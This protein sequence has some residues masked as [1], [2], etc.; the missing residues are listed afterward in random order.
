MHEENRDQCIL[1]SGESGSGKTEASKKILQYLAAAT[2]HSKKVD[3]VKDKLLQS[4]PVLE[5]EPVGGHILNYLLEK[6]R[7]VTQTNGERNFHVFYQLL[8]SAD[9][10]MLK[11]FHLRADADYYCYL[12]QGDCPVVEGIN[13]CSQF[14]TV[15]TA[16]ETI[17]FSEKE[18]SALFEIV[19]SV[20]HLGN[21]G[22]SEENGQ[23]IIALDKSIFAISQLLGCCEE[24]LRKAFTHRTIVAR[25]ENLETPLDRDQAIYARDALAKAIYERLFTWLVKKLNRSLCAKGTQR[26]TL[27]GIL[28]IYGFEIFE[29]NSLEQFCINYCN[30]KLQQLFIQLT[31]KSEQEEYSR[32]GI[33]W[34]AVKF[35]NNKTICDLVEE[36]H[37]GII[38][39]LI[40]WEV[41]GI[42]DSSFA[43]WILLCRD[44]ECLRPGEATDETFLTKLEHTVGTHPHFVSHSFLDKNNDLLFR[45]LKSVMSEA[46]NEITKETFPQSELDCKKRPNTGLVKDGIKELVKYLDYPEDEYRLGN[47]WRRYQAQELLKKR[48]W[49]AKIIRKFINGFILRN[50]VECE[51]NIQFVKRVRE[52]YL[53]RLS[54]NLPKSVTDKRWPRAPGICKETSE[55]LH[56]LHTK[57]LVRKYCRGITSQQKV[58]LQQKVV[59]ESLFRGKKSSYRKSIPKLFIDINSSKEH[60]DLRKSIFEQ[61]IKPMGEKTLVTKYDRHG[62]KSRTRILILTNV[63]IYLLED[64]EFKL[65]H[66]FL[67]KDITGLTVSNLNDGLLL[68]R[69]PDDMKKDKTVRHLQLNHI[70]VNRYPHYKTLLRYFMGRYFSCWQQILPITYRGS[71]TVS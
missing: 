33:Q 32:E 70:H 38:A 25:G 6:S 22:F 23:A 64:K 4:N 49:A 14:K 37:R 16:L 71:I 36:R 58:Q 62:Y 43:S 59:A 24:R 50:S 44:E 65:K 67:L 2:Y 21:I 66:R 55:F 52:E 19:A 54:K 61:A 10:S 13:D 3:S 45:D 51:E 48:R 47:N 42:K 20:L 29:H 26:K 68:L 9:E 39:V 5:G 11:R 57:W 34:E 69:I 28:D 12:N 8:A 30:E 15:K 41:G 7:V 56:D 46:K 31:L 63:A 40:K 17:G 60:E 18:E 35:F 1:I 27:M 53:M